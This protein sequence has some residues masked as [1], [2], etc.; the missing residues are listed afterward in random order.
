M[1]LSGS[2]PMPF[3][4]DS[5]FYLY[6]LHPSTMASWNPINRLLPDPNSTSP[7]ALST[8]GQYG[9]LCQSSAPN[10][11]A[12]T[13]SA[14]PVAEHT[15]LVS[16]GLME[17]KESDGTRSGDNSADTLA[18]RSGQGTRQANCM[19]LSYVIGP[20]AF[21]MAPPSEMSRPH[22][23]DFP[24]VQPGGDLDI[25]H[26]KQGT[27]ES[28]GIIYMTLPSH[29]TTSIITHEPL[30]VKVTSSNKGI[31]NS[32]IFRRFYWGSEEAGFAKRTALKAKDQKAL[33]M[34]IE[35]HSTFPETVGAFLNEQIE[36]HGVEPLDMPL[37]SAILTYGDGN[38]DGTLYWSL[39][40]TETQRGDE[41][42]KKARQRRIYT[43][44][45]RET[46][47]SL[48]SG[49]DMQT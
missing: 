6:L 30:H 2:R 8:P 5:Y 3:H 24:I 18:P 9:S 13:Y 22:G 44:G 47:R 21:N 38:T 19:D 42:K 16:E 10:E 25:N 49:G 14:A 32:V 34:T 46:Q 15:M 28:M 26:A 36:A 7:Q 31:E 35:L 4:M 1:M 40:P 20:T 33:E 43:K 45:R 39:T 23:M 17:Y 41:K 11:A 12:Q 48:T 37:H 27:I 29:I